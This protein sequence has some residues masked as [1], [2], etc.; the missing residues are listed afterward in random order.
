MPLGRGGVH[1][2]SLGEPWREG[3]HDIAEYR[4]PYPRR[5]G[6]A[7]GPD[8][9]PPRGRMPRVCRSRVLRTSASL[10]IRP[11]NAACT[12]FVACPPREF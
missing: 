7:V 12:P 6:L 10:P 11:S 2:I 9:Q 3:T 4:Y 8:M 5:R 1:T